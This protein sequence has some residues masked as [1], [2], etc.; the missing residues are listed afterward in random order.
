[1]GCPGSANLQ[2]V[3]RNVVQLGGSQIKEVLLSFREQHIRKRS[4]RVYGEDKIRILFLQFLL[5]NGFALSLV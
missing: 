4:L 5:W 3:S 1:M 2:L